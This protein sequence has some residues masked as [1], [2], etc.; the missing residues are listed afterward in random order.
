MRRRSFIRLFIIFICIG[1]SI[2][3]LVKDRGFLV[4]TCL[5][6]LLLLFLASKDI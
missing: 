1:T 2:L 6:T 4:L 3:Y 5:E